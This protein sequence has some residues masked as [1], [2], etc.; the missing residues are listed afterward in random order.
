M[1]L[2]YSTIAQWNVVNVNKDSARVQFGNDFYKGMTGLV[3]GEEWSAIIPI[4]IGTLSY[5]VTLHQYLYICFYIFSIYFL[6][7]FL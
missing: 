6:Y 4:C 5:T 3:F 2:D 1:V 7:I